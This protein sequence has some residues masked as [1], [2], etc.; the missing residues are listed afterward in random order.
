MEDSRY[1]LS[2]KELGGLLLKTV[3]VCVGIMVLFYRSIWAIILFPFVFAFLLKREKEKGSQARRNQMKEEFMHGV[4]VLNGSLQ[5]GLSME[6][7]WKEVEKEMKYLYGDTSNFYVE[8]KK[9][10]QRVANNLP[11]EKL[12]LEFAYKCKIDEIIQF[13]E[14][15]EYGKRSGSNWK[16]IIDVTVNQMTDRYEAK[17][18]IEV[19]VAEKKMEQQVMNILP[20]GMLAFLQFSAWEYMSVLYHNA[21]GIVCM[22]IFLIAYIGAIALSEKI[23]RVQI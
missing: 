11:I 8:L 5:A 17:Q 6:N 19:M 1:H 12:F 7:A 22:T 16:K 2:S 3:V 13:A 14:L 18:Q 4:S 21:F 23:L 10:N 15:L 20:L 9:I